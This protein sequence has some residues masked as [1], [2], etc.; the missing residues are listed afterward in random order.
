MTEGRS[1]R[2]LVPRDDERA[3]TPVLE[4]PGSVERFDAGEQAHSVGL[5]EERSAQIVRQSGNARSISFLAV[6]VLAIFIP[7]YWFY[8][9]GIPALGT[10]GRLSAEDD[11]QYVTDVGRGYALY[12]ANCARCHD[13]LSPAPAGN[14]LGNIGPPLND[15]AK[16]YNALTEDGLPGTGHLNP[17]YIETVLEVGGRY[18]CGDDDSVMPAWLQPNGPLNYREVEELIAWLTASTATEFSYDPGAHG[19]G[20]GEAEESVPVPVE[21]TGWRDLSYAPPPDAPTPPACWRNPSGAIGGGGGTAPSAAPIQSPGTAESPRM[22]EVVETPELMITD[23]AGTPITAIPVVPGEVIRFQVTNNAPFAHNFFIGE[24]A[25]LEGNQTNGL[26][27]VANFVDDTM[28]FEWEV[29]AEVP[30][31]EFACTIPGHYQTMHGDISAQE[32]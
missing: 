11:A 8:D 21:V 9:I 22:V 1:G 18:V 16:L 29:P 12:L 30:M 31:L 28:T 7:I 6:L 19:E 14:G 3:I 20:G 24:P 5:T 2:D 32:Q 26:T 23:S 17:N 4:T 27:G 10:E 15:Q 13:R 25:A